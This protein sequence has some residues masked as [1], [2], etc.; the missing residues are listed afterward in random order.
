MWVV[1][2][3]SENTGR[4]YIVVSGAKKAWHDLHTASVSESI[5][6]GSGMGDSEMTR[7]GGAKAILPFSFLFMLYA[8]IEGK[9]W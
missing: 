7:Q 9:K 6:N 1:K 3:H 2:S 5:E 4:K 8:A